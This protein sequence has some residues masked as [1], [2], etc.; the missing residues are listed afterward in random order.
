M[1]GRELVAIAL[2]LH[3]GTTN[4][5]QGSLDGPCQLPLTLL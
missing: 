3:G 5:G 4:K 1:D 2:G